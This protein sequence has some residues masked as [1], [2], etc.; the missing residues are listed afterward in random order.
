MWFRR[1]RDPWETI[2]RDVGKIID[3]IDKEAVEKLVKQGREEAAFAARLAAIRLA[4]ILRDQS[5]VKEQVSR[6]EEL[7]TTQTAAGMAVLQTNGH[8]EAALDDKRHGLELRDQ[9]GRAAI[10]NAK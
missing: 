6:A 7:L 10:H 5:L 3:F 2:V 8:S 9:L 4:V 1:N